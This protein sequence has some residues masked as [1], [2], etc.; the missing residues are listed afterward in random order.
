M[1]LKMW[2]MGTE[3]PCDGR[4]YGINT[5]T[6]FILVGCGVDLYVDWVDH[7]I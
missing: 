6:C 3:L 1:N 2:D 4:M 7:L 5:F